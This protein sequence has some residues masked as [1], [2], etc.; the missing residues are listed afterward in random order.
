MGCPRVSLLVAGVLLVSAHV[1][2]QS[3]RTYPA[4]KQGGNYMHNYYF[5]PAP[6]STPWAP[7]WSPDGRTIAIAMSGSIW[8]VD[9]STGAARELTYNTKY[10]S[11]PSWSP[12]G[13]WL[14]YTADDGG[15]TIQLEMLN[16]QTGESRALTSDP[17]IYMDPV[18]SPDGARLAY[19]STNPN[20]NF[21]VFI[22]TIKDG[23]F[24]GEEIAVT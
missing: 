16:V 17:H 18:F 24:A 1:A 9:P 23:Q 21:N 13:R 10:H 11:M 8:G 6:S 5:A 2:G 12:D 15:G 4:A 14:V 7:A 19:V 22:R 20:G 3:S